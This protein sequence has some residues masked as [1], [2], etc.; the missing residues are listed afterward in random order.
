ME[1]K[2]IVVD[3][4]PTDKKQ[5]SWNKLGDKAIA[6]FPCGKQIQFDL[7]KLDTQILKYYGGKQWISD[8][9]ASIKDESEKLAKMRE[10]YDEAVKA[11]LQLS[12]TGKIQIIGKTRANATGATAL[13]K[14]IKE[15]SSV[16]SLEGLVMKKQL[17]QLPGQPEFTPEDQK[18]LDEFLKLAAEKLTK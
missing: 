6:Y 15:T 4:K 10:V 9:V 18:K 11:G 1:T 17:A 8:Q 13:A 3:G 16:V 5:I 12:D 14:K 7:T 2:A